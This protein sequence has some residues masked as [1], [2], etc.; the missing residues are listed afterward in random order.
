MSH[1]SYFA[2]YKLFYW[3]PSI[4]RVFV[5]MQTYQDSLHYSV[6]YGAFRICGSRVKG[7]MRL[8]LFSIKL[9]VYIFAAVWCFE[10]WTS[11][12]GILTFTWLLYENYLVNYTRNNWIYRTFSV[13]KCDKSL[14][15]TSVGQ[16]LGI[17]FTPCWQ[18][19]WFHV[20]SDQL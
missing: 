12:W 15:F 17:C 10:V 14:I 7:C 6:M 9:W 13:M 20:L 2:I 5:F 1:L 3:I 19:L 18:N 4:V 8:E 11:F 16:C